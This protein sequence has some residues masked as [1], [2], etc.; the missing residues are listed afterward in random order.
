MSFTLFDSILQSYQQ[1]LSWKQSFLLP[2][3]KNSDCEL[4]LCC[5]VGNDAVTPPK[6][7]DQ[8]DAPNTS[9]TL[10]IDFQEKY[11]G[12]DA[13]ND[14]IAMLTKKSLPGSKFILQTGVK[15][16]SSDSFMRRT[17]VCGHILTVQ[18]RL[19][20]KSFDGDSYI[21]SGSSTH[22]LGIDFLPW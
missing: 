18:D 5:A 19:K 20:S 17:L 10:A 21:Q 1:S 14:I 16:K 2:S 4:D 8:P 3:G 11:Q 22:E 7:I 6:A 15:V 9:L 12:K 13:M